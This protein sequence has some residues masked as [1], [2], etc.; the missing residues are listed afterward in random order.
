MILLCLRHEAHHDQSDVDWLHVLHTCRRWRRLALSSPK[1]WQIIDMESSSQ[2]RFFLNYAKRSPITV[3][4]TI[5]KDLSPEIEQ[6]LTEHLD[7]ISELTLNLEPINAIHV[8]HWIARFLTPE[9]APLLRSLALQLSFDSSE[10]IHVPNAIWSLATLHLSNVRFQL[11]S[12]RPQPSVIV[13]TLRSNI[14]DNAAFSFVR[15]RFTLE[16][17]RCTPNLVELELDDAALGPH[18]GNRLDTNTIFLPSLQNFSFRGKLRGLNLF[19]DILRVSTRCTLQA[20]VHTSRSEDQDE[21]VDDLYLQLQSYLLRRQDGQG[22]PLPYR[23]Y[24][25]DDGGLQDPSRAAIREHILIEELSSELHPYASSRGITVASIRLTH[26]IWYLR[27]G[28]R[29]L[30]HLSDLI[31]GLPSTCVESVEME[32]RVIFDLTGSRTRILQGGSTILGAFR[33]TT[34]RTLDLNDIGCAQWLLFALSLFE[35]EVCLHN[36]RPRCQYTDFSA[37]HRTL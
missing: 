21:E 27:T 15:T 25:Q 11:S 24:F 19:C 6:M 26:H 33:S 18:T 3:H 36:T 28:D 31:R 14:E 20:V 34:L 12:L 35:G 37:Q 10:D 22:K 8:E 17:L 7:H 30:H 29:V 16:L 23:V 1:F 5:A 2:R 4:Q 13:L 32:S 9:T